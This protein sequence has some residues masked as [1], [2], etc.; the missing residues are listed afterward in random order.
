[1][2]KHLLLWSI[3]AVAAIVLVGCCCNSCSKDSSGKKHHKQ[4]TC[5]V[6]NCPDQTMETVTVEAVEIIPIAPADQNAN[7][8]KAADADADKKAVP[9]HGAAEKTAPAAAEKSTTA[10]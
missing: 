10:M 1:M 4:S 6:S 9:R 8:A 2:K 7:K 3:V 5:A